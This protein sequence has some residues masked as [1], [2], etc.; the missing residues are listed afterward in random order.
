MSS[1]ATAQAR[2]ILTNRSVVGERRKVCI[3]I[4]FDLSAQLTLAVYLRLPRV[5]KLDFLLDRELRPIHFLCGTLNST[6]SPQSN[7]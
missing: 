6:P 5:E 2:F 4:L 3:I 7:C 1:W